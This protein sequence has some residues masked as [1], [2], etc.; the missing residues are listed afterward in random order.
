MLHAITSINE[1]LNLI[2]RFS[3]T[4]APQ[5]LRSHHNISKISIAIIDKFT[6]MILPN[7]YHS[8]YFELFGSVICNLCNMCPL[9][10]AP[11]RKTYS[12]VLSIVYIKCSM[13]S[14]NILN[15]MASTKTEMSIKWCRTTTSFR[16]YSLFYFNTSPTIEMWH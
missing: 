6:M 12:R 2:R 14:K 13:T 8:C 4:S 16:K 7:A 5:W 10:A 15:C 9:Y 1:S 11:L 3:D